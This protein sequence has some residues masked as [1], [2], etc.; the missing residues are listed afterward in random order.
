MSRTL[1][2]DGQVSAI[3]QV[4]RFQWDRR[5]QQDGLF[6]QSDTFNGPIQKKKKKKTCSVGL[7]V[8]GR[9]LSTVQDGSRTLRQDGSFIG[10]KRVQAVEDGQDAFNGP[11]CL[12]RQTF[13][14]VKTRVHKM[15][16]R[17]VRL[18]QQN[19]TFSGP[20]RVQ[21]T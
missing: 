14:P 16:P 17:C 7:S 6:H 20:R 19:S 3:Q 9:A 12:A 8:N 5:C 1:W 18:F 10:P 15:S 4:G 11:R 13:S 21:N 2:Q